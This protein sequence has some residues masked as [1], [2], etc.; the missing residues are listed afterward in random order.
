MLRTVQHLGTTPS[1]VPHCHQWILLNNPVT[2]PPTQ[3][4]PSLPPVDTAEQSPQGGHPPTYPLEQVSHSLPPV[5]TLPITPSHTALLKL[6]NPPQGGHY[7]HSIPLLHTEGGLHHLITH[8]ANPRICTP[9]LSTP[10]LIYKA[11][12]ILVEIEVPGNR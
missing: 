8:K 1:P 10:A 7:A 5:D 6:N 12:H 2:H 9:A 11:Y 3:V 4:S